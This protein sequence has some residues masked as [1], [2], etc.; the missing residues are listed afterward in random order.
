MRTETEG[1]AQ[2]DHVR[3]QRQFIILQKGVSDDM[4]PGSM[5]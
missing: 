5:A 3:F 1:T 4:A 2:I